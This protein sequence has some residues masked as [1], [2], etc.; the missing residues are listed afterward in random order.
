MSLSN[1]PLEIH[2]LGICAFEEEEEEDP[3][4]NEEEDGPAEAGNLPPPPVDNDAFLTVVES[5]GRFAVERLSTDRLE[6][7]LFFPSL[8]F[9][10]TAV[11]LTIDRSL[12]FLT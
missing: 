10:S 1:G 2:P 3:L 9:P 11:S 4:V 5:E 12:A 8:R 7:F 6:A